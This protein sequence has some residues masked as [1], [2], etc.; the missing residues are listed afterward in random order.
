MGHTRFG[1]IPTSRKWDN[2]VALLLAGSAEDTERDI[3]SI[4]A[5]ALDAAETA[6]ENGIDDSG[7]RYTFYLLTQI[8]LAARSPDWRLRLAEAGINLSENSSFF[9]LTTQMQ[10][11]IDSYIAEH[12]HA[13]DVSEIAQQAANDAL[14]SLAA[15]NA[16]TL[17]GSGSQELQTAVRQLSTRNGFARLGQV[18]FGRFLYRFMSFYL[19]RATAAHVGSDRLPHIRNVSDFNSVLAAHCE[20]SARIV[21]DFCGGWYSRTEYLEGI[22]EQ[23]TSR[24]MAVAMRKLQRELAKQGAGR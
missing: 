12:G 8:V 14:A 23:N 4:A 24:F 13:S 10:S 17:F 5:S 19:S 22:Q 15:S 20:Q 11:A 18:F 16:V 1:T 2:V 21:R 3:G 6:L 9:D 7:L